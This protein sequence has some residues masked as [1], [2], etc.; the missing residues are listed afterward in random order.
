[1][2]LQSVIK[3]ADRATKFAEKASNTGEQAMYGK[4]LQN[5]SNGIIARL[6][7]GIDNGRNINGD[8]F[9]R[10]NPNPT[11]EATINMR[12]SK[13]LQSP[14]TPILH[15]R[16]KLR[17]SFQMTP[18]ANN[19]KLKLNKDSIY[20]SYGKYHNSGFKTGGTSA[21]P[22]VNVPA[23]KYWGIPKTWKEGGTAY[24]TAMREFA[25]IL[26]F[27]FKTYLDTGSLIVKRGSKF[28][29]LPWN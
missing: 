1:M 15:G 16:G 10:S 23:R 12:K 19:T 25:S 22:N 27:T 28:D 13:S 5:V 4:F 14:D 18:I 6:Q 24:N 26:E 9:K 21:I 8:P 2:A 17:D 29:E 3:L 11:R 20:D 7:W